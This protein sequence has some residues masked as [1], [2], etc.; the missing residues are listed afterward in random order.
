MNKRC[1]NLYWVIWTVLT[2]PYFHTCTDTSSSCQ[3]YLLSPFLFWM[4]LPVSFLNVS[5]NFNSQCICPFPFFKCFPASIMNLSS[6][7]YSTF[8]H[9][10]SVSLLLFSM[11]LSVVFLMC[12]TVSILKVSLRFYSESVSF[13]P[14]LM[15]LTMQFYSKYVSPFLFWM[16]FIIFNGS[17][18]SFSKYVFPCL[19]STRAILNS[20]HCFYF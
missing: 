2:E 18:L 12:L 8:Y 16:S 11:C 7:F 5:P 6:Q 20:F 19:F 4:Y 10:Q 3:R 15:C 9:S 13:F 1:Y 17:T 14:F